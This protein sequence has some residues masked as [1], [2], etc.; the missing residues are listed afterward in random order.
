MTQIC[1]GEG[2][3]ISIDEEGRVWS[4]GRNNYGQLGH[5]HKNDN[6]EF[7]KLLNILLK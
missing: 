1:C 5:G 7:P 2:H 4:W 3:T 6:K